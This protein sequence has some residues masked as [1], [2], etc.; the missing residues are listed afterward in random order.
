MKNPLFILC[1]SFLVL[2]S[3]SSSNDEAASELENYLIG[4]W[5]LNKNIFNNQNQ[6]LTDCA[7]KGYI[8]FNVN[9]TFLREYYWS[10]GA[11]C[12]SEGIDSGTYNY[13]TVNNTITLSF[14]DPDDGTQTE[15]LHILTLTE[16]S[17]IYEWDEGNIGVN[18]SQVE[19]IK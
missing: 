7:K 4:K 8:T 3:C 13:N 15:I 12:L 19:W 16:S 11:D 10:N 17:F 5:F 2:F 6:N 9:N 14:T 1:L 18:S